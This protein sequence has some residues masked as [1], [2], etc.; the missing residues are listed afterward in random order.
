VVRYARGEIAE[1][2]VDGVQ[3]RGGVRLDR[4]PV[5]G[6]E[7]GEPQRRHHRHEGRAGRLVTADLDPV[8]GLP[9]PVGRVDDAHR[10]PEH[11]ALDLLQRLEVDLGLGGSAHG[12][13]LGCCLG[14]L[15]G[16]ARLRSRT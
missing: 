2:V 5:A 13:L 10:E 11:P 7:V 12:G 15:D 14:R 1:Q 4:H 9:L 6:C 16:T 8:A 3:H